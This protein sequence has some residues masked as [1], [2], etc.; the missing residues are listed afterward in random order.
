MSIPLESLELMDIGVGGR[1]RERESVCGKRSLEGFVLRVR[2]EEE[3]EEEEE[4]VGEKER[5]GG[6]W[7][8]RWV[9]SCEIIC[10]DSL[11]LRERERE[12]GKEKR[13]FK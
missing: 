3:E 13:G 12:R 10:R 9:W 8:R 11:R 1:E 4:E 2:E 7:E 6:V 5:S